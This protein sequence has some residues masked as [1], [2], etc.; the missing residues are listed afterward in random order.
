MRSHAGIASKMF[1]TLADEGINIQM[2]ST[3]EIKISG[4]D[5]REV[6]RAR[7]ARAA[8]GV[9]AREGTGVNVPPAAGCRGVSGRHATSKPRVGIIGLGFGAQV[10]LPAFQ[11]EGWEVAAICSRHVDKARKAA[12]AAGVETSTPIRSS[13]SRATTSTRSRS[14]RRRAR[15]IRSRWRR[16]TR[17][18]TSCAKS[19]S[20]WTRRKPPRCATPRRA[21]RLHGHGRARVPATRRNARTSSSSW[22]RATSAGSG[23]A[24]SSCSSTAT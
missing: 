12:D 3:S 10:H 4:R 19:R 16:S 2:I 18:S 7:G 21:L 9:R 1:K 17:A 14:A 20:R 11:S 22:R 15:I 5:R 8:Q 6:P 24:R 13:S 23:C